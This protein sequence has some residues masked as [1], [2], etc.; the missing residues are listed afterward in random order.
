MYTGQLIQMKSEMPKDF[1]KGIRISAVDNFQGMF[2]PT[3]RRL[4]FYP[5][6]ILFVKRPIG[7]NKPGK[8]RK[9]NIVQMLQK[10]S[11]SKQVKKTIL[12]FYHLCEATKKAKLDS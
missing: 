3:F 6:N 1:F 8:L 10:S 11:V 5:L 12:L 4:T 9:G 2:L 7:Y